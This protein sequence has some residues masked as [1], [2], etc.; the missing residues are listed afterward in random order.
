MYALKYNPCGTIQRYKP[1]LVATG[2]FFF[3]WVKW[4]QRDLL[5]VM[6]LNFK[7]FSLVAKL[8][9]IRSLLSIATSL[10]GHYIT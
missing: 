7:T 8:N 5:T 2:F 1:R 10:V 9:L 4:R 3:F 6:A